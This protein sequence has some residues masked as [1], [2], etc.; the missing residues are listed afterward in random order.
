MQL[1]M[2]ANSAQPSN[3]KQQ[4]WKLFQSYAARLDYNPERWAILKNAE[5]HLAMLI[6]RSVDSLD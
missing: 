6:N 3:N 1:P 2:Q 5:Q 4:D